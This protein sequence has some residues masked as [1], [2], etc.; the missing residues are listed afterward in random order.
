MG[1]NIVLLTKVKDNDVRLRPKP[2]PTPTPAWNWAGMTPPV[3]GSYQP[4]SRHSAR[5]G[6]SA[7]RVVSP[8]WP[9]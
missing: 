7:P 3:M 2:T 1:H 8:P 6:R 5:F 9:G 4:R